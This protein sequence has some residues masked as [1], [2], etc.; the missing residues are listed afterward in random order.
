M[1]CLR[2]HS[3]GRAE[4]GPEFLLTSAHVQNP[5]IA[6]KTEMDI[7]QNNR[8]PGTVLSTSYILPHLIPTVT[9]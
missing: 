6:H 5:S 7:C 4:P 9:L 3:Q 1:T 2:S 8:M